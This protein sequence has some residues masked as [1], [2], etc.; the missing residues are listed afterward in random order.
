MRTF[1]QYENNIVECI[2]KHNIFTIEMI[3]TFYSGISRGHF[4][5]LKLNK[6]DTIKNCLDDNKNR[7]KHSMLSKWYKSENPTLQIALYKIVCSDEEAHRL[8]GSKTQS[9]ITTNGESLNMSADTITK[10][11]KAFENEL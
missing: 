9:D 4:Y 3:F 2:K 10:I 8:N 5:E 6:S 7:T 11:K 1:E